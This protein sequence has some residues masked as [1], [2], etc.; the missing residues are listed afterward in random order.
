MSSQQQVDQANHQGL[1]RMKAVHPVWA[2]IE[3]ASEA[4]HMNG[5]TL[6]HAGPPLPDVC[7]PPAAIFSSMVLSCLYEGWAKDEAQAEALIRSGKLNLLPAQDHACV[8][9]L[10]AII[11]PSSSLV[12]VVDASG[13]VTPVWSLLSSGPPPDI[14]FGSRD[15][16]C[17]TGMTY[18]DGELASLLTK[19]LHTPIDLV[20][21]AN[22]GLAGGDELH[23][24]TQSA[25]AALRV[26]LIKRLTQVGVAQESLDALSSMMQSAPGFFLTLWMAACRL[27][28]SASDGIEHC[29]LITRM[30]GN[31]ETV[32]Y[33]VGT[34]PGSWITAPAT[35]P[36]G[37]YFAH[38]APDLQPSG[39]VGDSAVVDAMG[40]GGQIV[41][42][43][44][45]VLA[46]L[47]NYLPANYAE[48][49][50]AIMLADL[51][52]YQAT[53][54]VR[55]G[56]DVRKIMASRTTPLV[57]IGILAAD[58]THGLLGR[59]LYVPPV[60]IFQSITSA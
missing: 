57:N 34:Q 46:S 50:H 43:A 25:T 38:H 32:G 47:V 27:Y 53:A 8:T 36:V 9:P 44:P 2:G 51:A 11:S 20:D 10:A 17:L 30:G 12:K 45:D 4:L 6:L 48:T 28:L 21:M 59:G 22:Q 60:E 16:G 7:N 56:L 58:G 24:R 39:V 33:S 31:G 42:H 37:S 54:P 14:R 40:F 3:R 35:P 18:R 49:K 52:A 19:A 41:S 13:T 1:E 55:C 26:E 23:S 29:S 5:H 15:L